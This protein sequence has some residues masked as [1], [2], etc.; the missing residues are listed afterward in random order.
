MCG[1]VSFLSLHPSNT[2]SCLQQRPTP[3]ASE[4]HIS[5]SR[6]GSGFPFISL[7][8]AQMFGMSVN[9]PSLLWGSGTASPWMTS[10][11]SSFPMHSWQ[12]SSPFVPSEL[13]LP[14]SSNPCVMGN[15][16]MWP[17]L[18]CLSCS[19][20]VCSRLI[21]VWKHV[22]PEYPDAWLIFRLQP[23]LCFI[24]WGREAAL[25]RAGLQESLCDL[26]ILCGPQFFSLQN[27]VVETD[28][29][30]GLSVFKR[31]YDFKPLGY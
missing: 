21:G 17:H 9:V 4:A 2:A 11:E 7:A 1:L 3:S 13:P 22:I 19:G 28:H 14:H 5:W 10:L 30:W 26:G 8:R 15:T 12:T 24:T 6:Q 16:F 23:H 29:L 20:H 25:G 31:L 18:P 27:E